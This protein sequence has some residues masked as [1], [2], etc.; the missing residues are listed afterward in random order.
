MPGTTATVSLSEAVAIGP[1]RAEKKGVV[2]V[3]FITG[4]GGRMW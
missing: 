3:A 1:R 4:T 2:Q